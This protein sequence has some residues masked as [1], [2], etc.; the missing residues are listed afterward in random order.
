MLTKQLGS[1][2]RPSPPFP[3]S[4]LHSIPPPLLYSLSSPSPPPCS[5]RTKLC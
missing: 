1:S 4:P 2:V 5:H 3:S